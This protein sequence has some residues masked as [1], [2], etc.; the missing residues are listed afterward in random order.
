MAKVKPQRGSG[1]AGQA[2]IRARISFLY[3]ASNYLQ[4]ASVSKS[5]SKG[6]VNGNS[7]CQDI[8]CRARTEEQAEMAN[9][10]SPLNS[11]T[12]VTNN[13][14]TD[15]AMV[16]QDG[17]DPAGFGEPRTSQHVQISKLS[18]QLASQMRGISLKSQLRLPRD[19]KRSVC[20]LCN[21][22]LIPNTTCVETTENFSRGGSK[23]KPWADVRVVRCNSC[24]YI[25]RY[26]QTEKRSLKLMERRKREKERDSETTTTRAQTC[27]PVVSVDVGNAR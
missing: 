10:Q 16:H 7:R 14:T 23:K 13:D 9:L 21:S 4:S 15:I 3:K 8:C 11:A 18:R 2:H 6:D 27:T 25:K 19:I 12:A 22:L 24:G 17:M 26:P 20:K 1:G 5:R